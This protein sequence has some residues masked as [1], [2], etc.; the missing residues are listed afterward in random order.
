MEILGLCITVFIAQVIFLSSRTWNVI[1][2]SK[3]DIKSALLSGAVVHLS[4]AASIAI[5]GVS[6]YEIMSSF[7]LKFIPVILCSLVGSLYGTYIP[8]KKEKMKGAVARGRKSYSERI[9]KL[10]IHKS[11][12]KGDPAKLDDNWKEK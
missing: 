3:L 12:G 2:I 6:M 8:L 5:V 1:A 11:D 9:N 7:E 4:W 10:L